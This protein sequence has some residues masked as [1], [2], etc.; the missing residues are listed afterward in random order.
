MR[1]RAPNLVSW[2]ER[3]NMVNPSVGDWLPDD[4]VPDTLFPILRHQ[5]ETQFPVLEATVAAVDDWVARHPGE[6]LPRKLGE[7]RFRIGDAEDNRGILSFPQ[8]KL[9]RPLDWYQGLDEVQREAV[10]AMLSA[11]GGRDAMQMELPRRVKRVNN[12]LMPA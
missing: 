12:R 7:H 8:W 2:I 1:E 11:V 4:Q 3:M 5:F 6:H 10:D 9:Q